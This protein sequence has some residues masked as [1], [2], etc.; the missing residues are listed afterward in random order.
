MCVCVCVYVFILVSMYVYIYVCG[1]AEQP[2]YDI[3]QEGMSQNRNKCHFF[4][5][6]TD[7]HIEHTFEKPK[8]KNHVY[9]LWY[10]VRHLRKKKR[11]GGGYMRRTSSRE[12]DY[13]SKVPVT[14][15]T[16]G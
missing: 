2:H 8:I 4:L 7:P 16:V 12:D 1:L 13:C 9:L 5:T 11:G 10:E 3:C 15:G 14:A 6:N